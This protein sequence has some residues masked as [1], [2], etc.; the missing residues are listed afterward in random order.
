[1]STYSATLGGRKYTFAGLASLLAAASPERSGDRLAGLAAESA[2]ARVAARWAL[3][4]V[5][6]ARFLAEPVIPYEDDDVTRLIV[7]SHDPVAFA[8]VSALTVGDFREWLLSEA[9]DATA[10]AALAPG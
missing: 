1:M 7:D 8:P 10:L 9:A 5:P 2:Q 6:L 3:A 4:E